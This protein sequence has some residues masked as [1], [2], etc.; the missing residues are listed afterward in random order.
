MRLIWFQEA[1]LGS[2]LVK[3]DKSFFWD[4]AAKL[5]GSA[6]STVFATSSHIQSHEVDRCYS[7]YSTQPQRLF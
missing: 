2:G 1:C 3:Y 6:L 7:I 4:L 5:V